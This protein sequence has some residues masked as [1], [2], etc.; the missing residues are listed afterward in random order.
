MISSKLK[1]QT[2]GEFSS[3]KSVSAIPKSL[4]SD[5]LTIIASSRRDFNPELHRNDDYPNMLD[6]R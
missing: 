3:G 5:Q 6:P 1:G 2:S 4:A